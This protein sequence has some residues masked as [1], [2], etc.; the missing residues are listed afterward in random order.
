[1]YQG[2]IFNIMVGSPSDVTDI[3]MKAVECI[4]YWNTLNVHDHKITLVPHH[5]TSSSYPS[6]RKPAQSHI[7]DV[8]VNRSDALVAIF[9]SR[10][11]TPT[12]NFLSG[13]VEEIEEHRKAN[14]PVM[15]FFSDK[16][17][18]SQDIEQITKVLKYRCQLTGL[19]ETFNGIADFGK[20]FAEK[21][22]LLVQNELIPLV[23]EKIDDS[24]I[25]KTVTFSD[26][27]IAIMKMWCA[28]KS[29]YLSRHGFIGGKTA[30]SF[31]GRMVETQ[32]ASET[33]KM[34]DFISRLELARFIE[35]YG[36]DKYGYPTYKMTLRAY[37]E[38]AS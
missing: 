8:M 14:K 12:D 37:E 29:N 34:D 9:G 5:W 6:L 19:Y 3:A 4:N 2:F 25:Q 27:E 30:F 23:P 11:G 10:L 31:S 36:F 22:H 38:F 7:D 13:T 1:M 24:S 26:D 21:L 15:V 20:K 17:D 18:S 32:S 16:F 35:I 28:A 33:A